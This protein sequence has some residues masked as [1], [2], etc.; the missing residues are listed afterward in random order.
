M[1]KSIVYKHVD[2]A[3]EYES[4]I[5]DCDM[6][7]AVIIGIHG[8][9]VRRWDG[10][11]FFYQVA[12]H[13]SDCIVALVDQN[14]QLEDGCKLNSLDIMVERNQNVLSVIKEKFPSLDVWIVAHSMGCGV[15]ALMDTTG[16]TGVIFVAP[17]VGNQVEKYIERYGA[18]VVNGIRTETTDGLVKY[19]SKEFMDSVRGI[20]WQDKFSQL[21]EKHSNVH[22]FE[23]GADEIV[24]DERFEL[25]AMPLASYTIIE[26]TPHNF[27]GQYPD[28]LFM[29]IDQ[30]IN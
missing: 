29:K 1:R 23:S 25:R 3:G 21:I 28:E 7:K 15:T 10:K 4:E 26:G 24:D 13:F 2:S 9:G 19:I 8:N 17:G 20:T 5:F 12:E 6:P 16:I 18:N 22:A 11:K 27:S 14:Q 30:I